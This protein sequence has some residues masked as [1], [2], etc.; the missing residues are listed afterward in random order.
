MEPKM[1]GIV[2]GWID[3]EDHQFDPLASKL[4][5]ELVY[6]PKNG[7][8][9]DE[10]LVAKMEAKLGLV[11]DIYEKRLEHS[12]YLGGCKFTSA[13]LTHLPN[14]YYLMGTKV[15]RLFP[16]RPHVSTWCDEI[17]SRPSW[18]KVV[19]MIEMAQL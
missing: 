12:K 15:K 14:L 7:L 10:A 19:E 4:R 5:W 2:A 16:S 1:Q 13:D 8:A 17:L 3:V 6:K 9:T 18:K 11:L